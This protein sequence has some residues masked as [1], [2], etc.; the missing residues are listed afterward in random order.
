MKHLTADEIL[1][2]VSLSKLDD[3]AIRLSAAVNGHIRQ[4]EKCRKLVS[5]FQLI[6]DE[7]SKPRTGGACRTHTAGNMV[8]EERKAAA[9]PK[10][11]DLR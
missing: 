5:A 3:E 10:F 9:L 2:F 6:Q 1:E 7:M 4:C 11:E 8:I